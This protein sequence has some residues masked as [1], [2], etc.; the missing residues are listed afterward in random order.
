[1]ILNVLK[2]LIYLKFQMNSKYVSEFV[3]LIN[4]I[5]IEPLKKIE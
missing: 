1:M 4:E 5:T 2:M 3:L